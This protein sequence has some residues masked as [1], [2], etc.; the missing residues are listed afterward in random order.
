MS[1]ATLPLDAARAA[2]DRDYYDHLIDKADGNTHKQV[3]N[4]VTAYAATHT[5]SPAPVRPLDYVEQQ[6]LKFE[7]R[8]FPNPGRKEQAIRDEFDWSA[9]RYYQRLNTLIDDPAALATAP[10]LVNRLRR[11]REQRRN[12]RR[13]PAGSPR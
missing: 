13:N 4:A 5:A 3:E 1:T 7:K 10:Q 2:A 12:L 8:R 6:I 11:L 9:T